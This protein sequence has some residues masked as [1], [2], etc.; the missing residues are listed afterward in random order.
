MSQDPLALAAFT[1]AARHEA[2]Y[3]AVYAAVTATERGRWF[4]SEYANRNRAA[5]TDQVVAALARIEA[6]IGGITPRSETPSHRDRRCQRTPECRR[7]GRGA[8]H[9]D[10]RRR[11]A[12]RRSFVPP[13]RKRCRHVAV[14]R[15]RGRGAGNLPSVRTGTANFATPVAEAPTASD[16]GGRRHCLAARTKSAGADHDRSSLVVTS[17]MLDAAELASDDGACSA[18]FRVGSFG[19]G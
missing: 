6:A 16:D 17:Q 13:A 5:N 3:D 15:H 1:S 18:R 4:L 7:R 14:R 9:Q 12:Y 11:R 2:E 19:S 10:H 8:D